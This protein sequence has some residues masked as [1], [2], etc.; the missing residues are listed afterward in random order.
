MKT[1]IYTRTGDKGQTSLFN[2]ERVEKDNDFVNALGIVD[3]CNSAIGAAVAFLPEE[4]KLQ[5][6]KEHLITVQHA[7]FDVGA[8]IATPRTRATETKLSKTRFD[9]NASRVLEE[10]IDQMD[11][12]LPELHAFILPGGHPAGA[13]LHL[14]RTFCRSAERAIVP[15]N[16]EADVADCVY[17]YMNR[18]SDFL[19]SASRYINMTLQ[20]PEMQWRS[21]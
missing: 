18:L 21:H 17:V 9:E 11:E 4:P 16:H 19:F 1:K 20:C 5:T 10:W 8:A 7:L 12:E 14:A 3:E 2:G 15:L 13:M 6:L